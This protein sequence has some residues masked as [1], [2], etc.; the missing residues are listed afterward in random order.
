[1]K[2]MK[3]ILLFASAGL[4]LT[5]CSTDVDTPQISEESA[6]TAPVIGSLGDVIVN[7]DNSNSET[8]V[9]HW[10]AADFGQPV[11]ILYSVYLASGDKT[12]LVGTTTS[13]SLAVTKGDLNGT[14][15][16]GLGFDAN[17]TVSLTAYV[18]AKMAGT[19]KYAP[20][21]SNRSNTFS[22]STYAAALKYLYLCGEF[23]GWTIGTAPIFW[24]TSGGTNTYSCMVDLNM[25]SAVGN[26]YS[27]FKVT[28]AQNWADSNW[29]YNYLTPSW[30]CPE[31]SDSNLS[32]PLSE[33]NI[34]TL[35]VNTT[36]MTIDHKA[37]GTCLGLIGDFN[38]WGADEFFTYDP[39]SSTWK[40]APVTLSAGGGVK[41]RANQ[42]WSLNWGMSGATSS[43]V[44][45][46]YE[47]STGSDNI[48]VPADGTYICVLH[49]NRTPYVFE[50]VK[51]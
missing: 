31:Q 20:I 35:T 41:I 46:G 6:F 10:S 18:T 42:A 28:V 24:E 44:P 12:A 51:Q 8:V 22:V 37:I 38:S 15:I 32:V 30:T 50:F 5:A 36:V 11:Q 47:L 9:F 29:G 45:G 13:T 33:G 16:S 23:N 40:T 25:G 19:D 1:M 14:V 34:F 4:L 49:A 26:A 17:E 39:V 43:A 21:S 7:A 3:H 48:P 2:F 27:Y